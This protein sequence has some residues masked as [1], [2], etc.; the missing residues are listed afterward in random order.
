MK[1]FFT[2]LIL[3][4]INFAVTAKTSVNGLRVWSG[5]D[6]TK[7]VIDLSSQVDY[8][9]FQLD[10]PPRVVIDMENTDLK[11]KLKLK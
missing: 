1:Y 11:K 7:A 8:K 6:E 4:V 10:N 9:L 5:P 3:V 2:I